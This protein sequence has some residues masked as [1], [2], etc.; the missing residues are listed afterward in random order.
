MSETGE[1][2]DVD[3]DADTIE[4]E[5]DFSTG[6]NEELFSECRGNRNRG[7]RDRNEKQEV[8]TDI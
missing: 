6:S 3:D 7:R 2:F 4:E 1:D 5:L 8:R